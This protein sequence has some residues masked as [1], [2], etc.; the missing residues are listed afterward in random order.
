[1]EVIVKQNQ[2][3]D[4]VFSKKHFENEN[5]TSVLCYLVL[6]LTVVFDKVLIPWKRN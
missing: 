6:A 2:L 3:R 4:L 5:F 1:M